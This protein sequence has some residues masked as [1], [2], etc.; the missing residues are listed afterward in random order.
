MFKIEAKNCI[1]C[2]RNF[3]PQSQPE[4]VFVNLV[5]IK[6][7]NWLPCLYYYITVVT[8]YLFCIFYRLFWAS[9]RR[10]SILVP[11]LDETMLLTEIIIV[12]FERNI[13]ASFSELINVFGHTGD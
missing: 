5:L 8:G 10:V 7:C 9:L 11:T 6:K 4:H 2:G 3:C 1:A 12:N 13:P